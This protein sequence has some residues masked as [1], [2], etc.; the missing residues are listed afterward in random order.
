ML[1]SQLQSESISRS[2][3]RGSRRSNNESSHQ[4]QTSAILKSSLSSFRGT[5]THLKIVF[6]PWAEHKPQVVSSTGTGMWLGRH[7]QPPM[8]PYPQSCMDHGSGSHRLCRSRNGKAEIMVQFRSTFHRTPN[9]SS[10]STHL[11]CCSKRK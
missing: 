8:Q 4:A 11:R 2:C 9:S 7:I 6:Y 10:R 5:W 1:N 3:H